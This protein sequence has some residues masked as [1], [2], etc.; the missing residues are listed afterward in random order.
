MIKSAKSFAN[1][2]IAMLAAFGFFANSVALNCERISFVTGSNFSLAVIFT[3]LVCFAGVA[4]TSP[5]VASDCS[6]R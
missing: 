1:R 5:G 4:T 2:V 6:G 3:V